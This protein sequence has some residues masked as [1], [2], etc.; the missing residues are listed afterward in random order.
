MQEA[1]K[2]LA[3]N[4][5]GI[6]LARFVTPLLLAVALW[7][8]SQYLARLDEAFDVMAERLNRLDEN[9]AATNRQIAAI[10]AAREVQ[11]QANDGDLG[12]VA[13][14]MLLLRSKVDTAV[15]QI[16]AVTAK[17]DILLD[18]KINPATIGEHP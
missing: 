16:T 12:D 9:L 10:D 4:T 5:W 3:E 2:K 15:T 7:L 11:E 13:R 18:G 6:L 1:T 8:G 17:V 14:E